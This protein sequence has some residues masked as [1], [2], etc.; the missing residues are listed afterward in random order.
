MQNEK[1]Q[2]IRQSVIDEV[3]RVAPNVFERMR[4]TVDAQV[5]RI[6][7]GYEL[8]PETGYHARISA[9]SDIL[10]MELK[11]VQIESYKRGGANGPR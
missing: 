10:T 1:T 11:L 6:A 7:G 5:E 3:R 8:S 4:Q 2:D 9:M